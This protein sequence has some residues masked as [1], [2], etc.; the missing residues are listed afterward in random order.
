MTV[1]RLSALQSFHPLNFTT[2]KSFSPL[3]PPT[4]AA[5]RAVESE[6]QQD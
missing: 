1:D 5:V 6:L 2:L 4:G 3:D